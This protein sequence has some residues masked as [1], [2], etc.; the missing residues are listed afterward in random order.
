MWIVLRDHSRWEVKPG[1][2]IIIAAGQVTMI[3]ALTGHVVK[4]DVTSID[5][6]IG[7]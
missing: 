7:N 4:V 2:D 5:R 3:S 1:T 6:I